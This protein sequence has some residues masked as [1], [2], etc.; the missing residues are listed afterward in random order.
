MNCAA[1]RC[2]SIG[3]RPGLEAFHTRV[4]HL[5]RTPHGAM[6]HHQAPAESVH[7]LPQRGALIGGRRPHQPRRRRRR[8]R[9]ARPDRGGV[10]EA[11]ARPCP[12]PERPVALPAVLA[13][14]SWNQMRG[15][16]SLLRRP[17]EC[18][19]CHGRFHRKTAARH[20]PGRED[21]PVE[22]SQR[23]RRRHH[24]RR[25]GRQRHREPHAPR[26][27]RQ[28][29]RRPAAG[30]PARAAAHRGGRSAARHSPA[31]HARRHPRPP[32]HLSAAARACLQL[33]PRSH[34]PHRAGRRH[35]GRR[36]RHRAHLGADAGRLARRAL[37]A[38]RRK[39]GRGPAARLGLRRAP[40]SRAF[41]ATISR[42]PTR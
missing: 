5:V 2:V 26:R 6:L 11:G 24:R 27:G 7:V 23:H 1:P 4:L 34:P 3:H 15:R 36:R 31:V 16:N 28:P 37:G 8:H 39:P 30:A 35:R 9:V 19:A 21:R 42:G 25:R 18:A 22:P 17:G 33:R 40:W 29:G 10:Q 41:R 20:E 13:A 38:L 32:H 12:P 14:Q